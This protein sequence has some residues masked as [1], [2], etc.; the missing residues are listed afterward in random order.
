MKSIRHHSK[1]KANRFAFRSL[2]TLV[3]AVWVA[4]LLAQEVRD[5]DGNSGDASARSESRYLPPGQPNPSQFRL[6]VQVRNTPT[7]VVITKVMPGSVAQQ[8]GLE[9]GD[10]ILTVSGYQVGLVEGRSYDVAEEISLRL[11]RQGS[12]LLLV[13]N[14][15]NGQVVNIPVSS[16]TPVA[17]T[18]L[19]TAMTNDR[20]N[21]AP[22]MTLDIRLLDITHPQWRDV[23]IAESQIRIGG[24]WPIPFRIDY[25]PSLIRA[26]HRY[27]VEAQIS[28]R[29]QIIQRTTDPV[30]VNLS[31][32]TPRVNLN[33]VS[34][35]G[36]PTTPGPGSGGVAAS[37]IDQVELWYNELLGRGLTDRERSVWQRELSKGKPTLEILATIL[38]SSEYSDRFRGN[39][40]S[41]ITSVFQTLYGRS[42][43]P[44]ELARWQSRLAQL[45]DV[46]YDLVM[47]MLRDSGKR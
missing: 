46:R 10:T 16:E 27:A 18:I 1:W 42:P 39:T 13:L 5:R 14:H 8:I 22:G 34:F 35:S 3:I 7:G 9:A 26:N 21:V 45:R 12:A 28:H 33:L 40:R 11:M 17:A 6:G 43:S 30:L 23:T 24:Q 29:G 41:Y 36:P 38:G 25:D 32:T 37:P 31:A 44:Q 2:A 47:E 4:P 15:R 19:G 20:R